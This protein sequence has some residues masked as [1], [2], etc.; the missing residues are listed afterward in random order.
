MIAAT[1]Q[2]E[3]AQAEFSFYDVRGSL[4]EDLS[5]TGNGVAVKPSWSGTLTNG[6]TYEMCGHGEALLSGVW[7]PDGS[8]GTCDPVYSK[9]QVKSYV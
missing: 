6:V 1:D 4:W 8:P 7:M 3:L 2:G 5:F 9:V